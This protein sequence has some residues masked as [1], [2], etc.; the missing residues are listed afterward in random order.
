M[1]S[2]LVLVG[3][4]YAYSWLAGGLVGGAC[5]T[6]TTHT[7]PHTPH[8]TTPHTPHTHTPHTPHHTHHT[9]HTCRELLQDDDVDPNAR[10]QDQLTA[11]QLAM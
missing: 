9:T 6:H 11:L 3:C 2:W 4:Q 7:T 10:G 1:L 8:H 5:T